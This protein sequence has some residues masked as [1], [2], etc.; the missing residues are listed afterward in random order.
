MLPVCILIFGHIRSLQSD[1][2][3]DLEAHFS[4]STQYHHLIRGSDQIK[5][6][7]ILPQQHHSNEQYCSMLL[8]PA[9][10]FQ[11]IPELSLHYSLST[12]MVPSL[13]AYFRQSMLRA[14]WWFYEPLQSMFPVHSAPYF[15]LPLVF[16]FRD[17]S[18]YKTE[19]C[20]QLI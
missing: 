19:Q 13:Q 14:A 7:K 12:N 4:W 2:Y 8:L 11:M 20:R 17:R 6:N 15:R 16:L 1:L 9:I 5:T 10:R 18:T 3:P